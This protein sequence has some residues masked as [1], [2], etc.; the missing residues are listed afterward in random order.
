MVG[1]FSFLSV[2][3]LF[4]A[5]AVAFAR[6]F[7][8]VVFFMWLVCVCVVWCWWWFVNRPLPLSSSPSLYGTENKQRLLSSS[9]S[10]CPSPSSSCSSVQLQRLVTT[11]ALPCSKEEAA[12][13]AAIQLR[14]QECSPTSKSTSCSAKSAATTT[15]RRPHS[16]QQPVAGRSSSPF[17]QSQVS[18]PSIDTIGTSY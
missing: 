18:T 14:L 17:A 12:S 10:S 8:V 3:S 16:P 13:L 2:S 7:V 4:F 5:F 15:L 1:V 9:S 11:G 6:C